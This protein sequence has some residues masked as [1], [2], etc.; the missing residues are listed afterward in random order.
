MKNIFKLYPWR[1]V[2]A[3]FLSLLT[4]FLLPGELRG[5]DELAYGF[6][7]R[8]LCAYSGAIFTS[9]DVLL[10]NVFIYWFDYFLN[11]YIV[12]VIINIVILIFRKIRQT[13]FGSPYPPYYGPFNPLNTAYYPPPPPNYGTTHP[14]D[15]TPK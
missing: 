8:F 11:S 9:H 13:M 12:A 14:P 1:F 4:A 2:L 5:H 7:L 10:G 6:P 3:L 15:T